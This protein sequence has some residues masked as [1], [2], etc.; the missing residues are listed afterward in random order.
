M[1]KQSKRLDSWGSVCTAF[2]TVVLVAGIIAAIMGA[3][4]GG[5]LV[6]SG[7]VLLVA[8]PLLSGLAILVLNAEEQID[9][10]E[11]AKEK[12]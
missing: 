1:K 2:G 4:V 3:E 9:A 11:D 10:R 6:I 8:G 7:L 5:D 12:Q